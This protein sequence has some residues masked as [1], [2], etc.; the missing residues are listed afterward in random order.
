MGYSIR[1]AFRGHALKVEW[2]IGL[3]RKMRLE[4]CENGLDQHHVGVDVARPQQVPDSHVVIYVKN[5][6]CFVITCLSQTSDVID[7]NSSVQQSQGPNKT[8]WTFV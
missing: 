7:L 2:R 4:S 8:I 1:S 5:P 3:E 6:V